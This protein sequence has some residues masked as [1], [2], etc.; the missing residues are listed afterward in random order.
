MQITSYFCSVKL[1]IIIPVYRVEATLDRCLQSVVSQSFRDFELILVD[2]GSPDRCPQM[3]DEWARRDDRIQVVHQQ[4]GGLSAARNTGLDLARGD[5]VTFI[6][7]DDFIA[8]DTLSALAGSMNDYDIV[9]YPTFLHYDSPYQRRLDFGRQ[10]YDDSH[11]YWLQSRAYEHCYAWNKVYRRPLFNTVRFP[12]GKVFEDVYTLPRL[13]RQNPVIA[14][15]SNGLYYY[16]NNP[17][18]ITAT[19]RGEQLRMLLDAHLTSA[20]PVDDAYYLYLLNIQLDVS[21]QTGDQPLLP[22]RHIKPCGDTKQKLKAIALNKL[23]IKQ[24][25][26]LNKILHYIKR[27]SRW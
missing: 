9:E 8:E 3:C 21:E 10:T 24:I 23:G 25:C 20:M 13:L 2:D 18:G 7:S 6:D 19:A 14:T 16:C 11:A 12:V 17:Q 15:I 22:V 26:K 1:S 5:Y 4:N 27:P